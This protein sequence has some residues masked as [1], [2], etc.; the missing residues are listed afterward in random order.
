MKR[1]DLVKNTLILTLFSVIMRVL[2]LIFQV[3]LSSAIGS[4]GMGLFSLILTVETLAITLA[5]SGIRFAVMRAVAEAFALQKYRSIHYLI[6]NAFLYAAAFGS[7]STALLFAFSGRIASVWLSAPEC[8]LPI[9]IFSFGLVFIAFSSV[10]GGYFSALQK[11]AVTAAL[12]LLEQLMMMLLC[13]IIIPY[14][15]DSIGERCAALFAAST[16]ADVCVCVISFFILARSM[17]AFPR[18]RGV[19]LKG[20]SLAAVALPL[21]FS[22]YARAALS[23]LQHILIPAGLRRSGSSA[24]QA[25][26]SYGTIHGMAFPVI[27]FPSAIFSALSELLI[28][29]ITQAQQLCDEA[30]LCG[31]SS[32]I[33]NASFLFSLYCAGVFFL[34][35]KR[36]G[37]VIYGEGEAGSYIS[38]LSPLIIVMYMDL[39]TDGMLKGFGQQLYSMYVNIADAALSLVLTW[40]LIPR[41]GIRGYIFVLFFSEC[42]NYALSAA[43]LASLASLRIPL[44]SAVKYI[45]CLALAL[46]AA[47]T[48]S[49][50]ATCVSEIFAVI[51]AVTVSAGI[52]F[53]AI[54]F[55][56]PETLGRRH[57]QG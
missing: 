38:M 41:C 12:Q 2:G 25:L 29:E 18:I 37:A 30:A 5:V 6:K 13:I 3:Y 50:A 10:V 57:V 28:P 21:A 4:E 47:Y 32:R 11:P 55:I 17:R 27:V 9:R 39:V 23:T 8:V 16:L 46:F 31:R 45:F 43:K 52:Y 14:C 33:L 35:G 15:S 48:A 22:S 51:A 44:L 34:F 1:N 40:F 53:P 56:F 24:S 7:A 19:K 54:R 26:A 42:F 20:H 36:L 49:C